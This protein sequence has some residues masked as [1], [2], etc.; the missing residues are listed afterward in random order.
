MILEGSC[1]LLISHHPDDISET[2]ANSDLGV[3]RAVQRA[4][5]DDS[6]GIRIREA[7]RSW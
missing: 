5:D 1:D 3:L 2:E 6:L 7:V 4:T